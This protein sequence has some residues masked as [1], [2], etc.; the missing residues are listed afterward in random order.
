[1]DG[2]SVAD[3]RAGEHDEQ[4]KDDDGVQHSPKCGIIAKGH[5][6]VKGESDSQRT[7]TA[8]VQDAFMATERPFNLCIKST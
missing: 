8:F 3:G 4:D 5:Q 1:M 7:S 6:L 2:Q